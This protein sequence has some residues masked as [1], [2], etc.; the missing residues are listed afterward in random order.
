[1][2]NE[3][4]PRIY[5]IT[6]IVS[7]QNRMVTNQ[8][9]VQCTMLSQCG[10][11][12][13]FKGKKRTVAGYYSVGIQKAVDQQWTQHCEEESRIAAWNLHKG[14]LKIRGTYQENKD[15]FFKSKTVYRTLSDRN[16]P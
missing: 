9:T 2:G 16:Q 14:I 13:P 6:T 8:E 3:R 12:V 10:K 15:T 4:R 7:E 5:L 1:M 11:K